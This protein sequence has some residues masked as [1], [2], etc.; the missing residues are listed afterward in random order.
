MDVVDA[1]LEELFE[2]RGAPVRLPDRDFP[3]IGYL[4]AEEIVKRISQ[5]EQRHLASD[6][7][8]LQEL[9]DEYEGWLREA[10]SKG[11]AIVFFYA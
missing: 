1:G 11:K 4:T 7:H 2:K 10:A 3:A 8:D 6:D 5:L 9:L